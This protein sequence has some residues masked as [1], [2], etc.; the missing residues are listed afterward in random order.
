MNRGGEIVSRIATEVT[1][2]GICQTPCW[3]TQPATR[4]RFPRWT[5]L[6]SRWS[7]DQYTGSRYDYP[8]Q[9]LVSGAASRK[10][11]AGNTV[12][13]SGHPSRESPPGQFAQGVYVIL[14][15]VMG[16][17]SNI[18]LC[19]AHMSLYVSRAIRLLCIYAN[20]VATVSRA[21]VSNELG[22]IRVYPRTDHKM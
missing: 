10:L 15:K 11:H 14:R 2:G 17:F 5:W 4:V 1:Y 20:S 18:W 3:N 22:F 6:R 9:H 16:E 13:S 8:R 21:C 19:A 7:H 12:F